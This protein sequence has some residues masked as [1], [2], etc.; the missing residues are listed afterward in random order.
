ME[1]RRRWRFYSETAFEFRCQLAPHADQLGHEGFWV[2]F[3]TR[4]APVSLPLVF[5]ERI[6]S[7]TWN[8]GVCAFRGDQGK[9]EKAL[10]S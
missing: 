3:D 9:E 10:L 6:R 8:D 7:E 1:R 4:W 5:R 2:G